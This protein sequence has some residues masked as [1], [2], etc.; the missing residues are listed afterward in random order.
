MNKFIIALLIAFVCTGNTYADK[1]FTKTSQDDGYGDNAELLEKE[2]QIREELEFIKEELKKTTGTQDTKSL[3]QHNDDS[4]DSSNNTE[5]AVFA[6]VNL[7]LGISLSNGGVEYAA[8]GF[9]DSSEQSLGA[10]IAVSG[11]YMHK[12]NNIFKAG[13]GLQIRHFAENY[14]INGNHIFNRSRTFMPL[15]ASAQANPFKFDE[16]FFFKGNIGYSVIHDNNSGDN[17]KGGMYYGIGVGYEF[18]SGLI[19]EFIYE[20]YAYSYEYSYEY[21]WSLYTNRKVDAYFGMTGINFG[22]KFKI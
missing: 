16:G 17:Q 13:I 2:K 14:T 22:Y 4:N 19:V 21:A 15:Y 1:S 6:D 7:R 9:P 12:I 3:I 8:E 11:E 20:R 10:D 5:R 18:S